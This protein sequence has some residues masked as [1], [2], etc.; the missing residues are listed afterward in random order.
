M[1]LF[2]VYGL[3][4]QNIVTVV[5]AYAVIFEKSKFKNYSLTFFVIDKN[6]L[7]TS[8]EKTSLHLKYFIKYFQIK[9]L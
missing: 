1:T 4:T 2:Q 8:H 9:Y 7:L 5:F 6:K 3:P